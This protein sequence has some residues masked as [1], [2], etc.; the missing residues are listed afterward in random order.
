MVVPGNSRDLEGAASVT[1]MRRAGKA[2]LLVHQALQ[3]MPSEETPQVRADE[4]RRLINPAGRL[5]SHVRRDDHAGHL[6]QAA[7]GRK[8][9]HLGDVQRRSGKV[10]DLLSLQ[11]ADRY[12]RQTGSRARQ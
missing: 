6:P 2:E 10:A 8:R 9:F 5:G 4:F 1:R 7:V 12:L 11:R 3:R